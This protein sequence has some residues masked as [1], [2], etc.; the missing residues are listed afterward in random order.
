MMNDKPDLD[1]IVED[2]IAWWFVKAVITQFIRVN[3]AILTDKEV[4][5]VVDQVV[6]NGYHLANAM[7]RARAKILLGGAPDDPE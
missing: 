2:R 6:E 7:K 4:D 1:M 5:Q 3:K